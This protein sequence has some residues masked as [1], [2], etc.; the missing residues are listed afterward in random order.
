MMFH[1]HM[2]ISSA[3][4]NDDHSGTY[5]CGPVGSQDCNLKLDCSR[6]WW[7]LQTGMG[8]CLFAAVCKISL[9]IP[10]PMIFFL[11]VYRP[12]RLYG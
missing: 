8:P 7:W 2:T 4:K 1:F 5:G 11:K 9:S 10:Q 3:S 12:P 6:L